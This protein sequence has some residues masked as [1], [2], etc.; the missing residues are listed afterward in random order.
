VPFLV[1]GDN[2]LGTWP[3]RRRS[4][5]ERRS[6][7]FDLQ[8][9]AVRLRRHVVVVFDGTEPPE[10]HLGSDVIFAGPSRSADDA[11]LALLK[12]QQNPRGWTVVTSDRSL[13]DQ[14]RWIGA[15]LVR[16]DRFRGRL[17]GGSR[18]EKPD[19]ELDVDYWLERFTD[20]SEP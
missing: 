18:G 9:L 13:G 12:G 20:G 8:R 2:L 1:D 11:I 10:S 19:R 3:G 15:T 7:A 17:A 4:D 6:L 5:S 14:C 16:C